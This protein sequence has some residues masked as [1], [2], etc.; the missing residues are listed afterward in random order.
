MG[1][2]NLVIA[3]CLVASALSPT[4]LARNSRGDYLDAHNAVRA[5]VGVDP[6]VWNKTLADYA[7]A[8]PQPNFNAKD[9]VKI[10]AD[11][12]KFYDRK[13]NSCKGGECGHYTQI[14]WH[15][16]SQVGC[17][18]VKCKNGHTFIS[19]NYYPIGNV[20]GQSPY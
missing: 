1:F 15:D 14:V 13:S 6:L 19:C 12:K 3:L 20:Q 5:E 8:S 10:W 16:T 11:E 9:A 2:T 4:C 17:A 18:R 7:K